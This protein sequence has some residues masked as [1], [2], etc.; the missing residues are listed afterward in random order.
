MPICLP[1]FPLPG[2]LQKSAAKALGTM[3]HVI[4]VSLANVKLT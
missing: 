1:L 4:D 3:W 2:D